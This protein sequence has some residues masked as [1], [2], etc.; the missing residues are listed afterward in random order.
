MGLGETR[1]N[2]GVIGGGVLGLSLAHFLQR[3]GHRVD[4]FERNDF[5]GGLACSYDYGEF[6]WDK[7]YH[8]ILAQDTE[9]LGLLDEL[10]LRAELRW[11][12]TGTGLFT[13]G[14]MYSMSSTREMLAFPLLSWPDKLRMGAATLYALRFARREDLYRLT[15]A[16]WL[17]RVFGRSNYEVLWRPLLRAKFGSYA[18]RIAAIAIHA[19]IQRLFGARTGASKH[20]AMGYVHGGYYRIL[21]AFREKLETTGGSIRLG[22]TISRIG[23]E[24]DFAFEPVGAMSRAAHGVA[25]EARAVRTVPVDAEAGCGVEFRTPGSPTELRWYD[26]V[27]F[28]APMRAALPVAGPFVRDAIERARNDSGDPSYLGVVC[29]ALVLKRPLTPFYIVNVADEQIPVTGLI[30]M[31][32]LVD[33]SEETAGRALVYL[34]RYVDSQDPLLAADD[35][36]VYREF[37]ERGLRRIFPGLSDA[38]IV[39]WH[40]QR[41]AY[42]QPLRLAG[43]AAPPPGNLM[44]HT[45]GPFILANTSLLACPTLNNNE[46]VGLA[47]QVASRI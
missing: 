27:V 11:R 42:V 36:S 43:S 22:V 10:G 21:R 32:G 37:V 2:V 40:V 8:V 47:R 14:R 9:L 33:R 4:V 16:E 1:V 26:K 41:A 25:A 29:L 15:A 46:V 28:T 31:T 5:L 44:P 30:E 34:P 17:S 35:A 23:V 13:K 39:S 19:A 24:G 12:P 18:D 7:F 20:E 3:R 45:D 6:T 38:D